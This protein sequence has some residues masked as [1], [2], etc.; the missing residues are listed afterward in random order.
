MLKKHFGL[1]AMLKTV[2]L[3]DIFVDLL[4]CFLLF[5]SLMKVPQGLFK[6]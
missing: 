4:F 6:I 1:L 5:D 3:L 2:M